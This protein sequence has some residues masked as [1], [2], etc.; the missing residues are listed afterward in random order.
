MFSSKCSNS[1]R[2]KPRYRYST[3]ICNTHTEV[4]R[5]L[6]LTNGKTDIHT[7]NIQLLIIEN[8]KCPNELSPTFTWDYHD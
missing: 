8:Y 5:E 4:Y 3:A 6:L 2:V 7:Q 1:L